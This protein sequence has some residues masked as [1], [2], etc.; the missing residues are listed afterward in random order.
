MSKELLTGNEAIARG[1]YEAGCLLA[2]AYPGTPSTEILENMAQYPEVDSRWAV[3]EKVALEIAAGASI[4]GL[5]SLAAM[6]HVGVNVAADP[7]FT[8]AYTGVNGG[9]VLISADDPGCHSSQNEQDN[10]LY[11]PLAKLLML[12]PSDSAECKAF[13]MEGFRLSEAYDIPVLLRVTTRVCHS[14]SL[15]ELGE[16][17]EAPVKPYTRN[18]AKFSMLP[19]PARARHLIV[20]KNLAALEEFSSTSPLNRV[21]RGTGNEIGVVA[22]GISYQYAREAFGDS[23]SYLKLGLTHPLPKRLMR[24][25]AASVKKIH[26][27]EEG[28]PYLENA[29]RVL[30]IDCIGKERIPV[31]G[32]LDAGMVR[33]AFLPAKEARLHEVGVSL[34]ARPPMLCA[35]CPHRGFYYALKRK[36]Q[37]VAVGDI[38]CYSLGVNP[39]LEAFDISI[40]MGAGF[41]SAI[42]LERAL[43]KQ[44]DTRKVFGIVG[45]STFFH[46]GMTGLIEAV[47]DNANVCLCI[48]DNSITAMTGHQ[49]NPGTSLSLTGQAAPAV[50][51]KKIVEAAGLPA[52]RIRVVDPVDQKAMNEAL[53]AAIASQGAFVIITKSPCVLLKD[54]IRANAGKHC[55]V[56]RELCTG[57]K[58]CLRLACPAIFFSGGKSDIPDP[59]ACTG[60]GLCMQVCKF[61]AITPVPTK[62]GA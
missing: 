47:H 41:S 38:G 37:A 28:E 50:D 59:A 6:K 55:A 33:A 58:A 22:S 14:K 21:E 17:A 1:A 16:R 20:E 32:E 42:G 51:I 27:I 9:L 12:E 36:K 56:N 60:C 61:K 62:A 45:D 18:T 25:F 15:V 7:L 11:A 13:T 2:A 10:R 8:I 52:D 5:R 57:C 46:S 35:G 29:L 19:G 31:C 44:G 23:V 34:P 4:G 53:D 54:V 26:V 3:N 43:A 48:L 49:D 39:P 30:G 40:C 24:E